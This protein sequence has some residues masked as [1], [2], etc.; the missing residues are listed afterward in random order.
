MSLRCE[1]AYVI[2]RE[3]RLA[4]PYLWTAKIALSYNEYR[5]YSGGEIHEHSDAH[6]R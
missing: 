1:G 6:W 3:Y 4:L 5:G 2:Y